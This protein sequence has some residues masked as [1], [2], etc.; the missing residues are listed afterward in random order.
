[1]RKVDFLHAESCMKFCITIYKSG[2]GVDKF[3][4]FSHCYNIS[5]MIIIGNFQ[6]CSIIHN[7]LQPPGLF[8]SLQKGE[9]IINIG[10]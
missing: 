2:A 6:Q 3:H 9:Y 1:M 8:D 5:V 7:P 10:K 4:N